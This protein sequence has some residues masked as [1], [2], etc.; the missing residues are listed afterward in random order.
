MSIVLRPFY[1]TISFTM[2]STEFPGLLQAIS[3]P[4]DW[5]KPEQLEVDDDLEGEQQTLLGAVP[6]DIKAEEPGTGDAQMSDLHDVLLQASKGVTEGT[7]S[8]YQS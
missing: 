6:E 3:P 7:D 8:G 5:E 4:E 1:S 2:T